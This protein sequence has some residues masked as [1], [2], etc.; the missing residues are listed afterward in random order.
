MTLDHTICVGT[1]GSGVW[2]S[3]DSGA[4]WRQARMDVPFQAQP[5]EIQIRALAAA[6]SN[7]SLLFAGSEAG[8]YRSE[9]AGA[10]WAHVDSPVDGAQVWSIGVHPENPD[11]V[12][13]GAKPPAL[14]RTRDG[15]KHWEELPLDASPQCLA[16]PPKITSIVFDPRNTETIWLSVE[17]DGVYRSQ[18]GGDTW[19]QLPARGSNEINEDVH[20][21]A[22]SLAEHAKVLT[23]TPDGIWTS[24]DEGQ[25]WSLHEF[26]RFFENRGISYCRGV[27]LKADDANVIFVANG[28]M[29]PGRTGAIQRSTDGGAAGKQHSFPTNPTRRCTGLRPTP[30]TPTSSL[31]TASLATCTS[32]ATPGRPGRRSTESSA[33]CARLRGC[34]RRKPRS[35]SGT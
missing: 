18:D 2:Y 31:R 14:Y 17:I 25:T 19:E 23:A 28:N 7:P 6:P 29:V 33:K 24:E 5:G 20:C 30:P 9:D 16:G 27:G 35:A 13:V 1:V 3:S 22:L 10:H 34:L 32:A 8:V 12:L 11:I 21:L 4:H 26:P 15:G